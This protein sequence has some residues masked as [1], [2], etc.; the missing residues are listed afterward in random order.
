MIG[1][2]AHEEYGIKKYI[3]VIG[4]MLTAGAVGIFIFDMLIF[5]YLYSAFASQSDING[6]KSYGKWNLY[7]FVVSLVSS[8]LAFTMALGNYM[9]HRKKDKGADKV[10][11][12]INF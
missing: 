2:I 6:Q 1:I 5:Q 3:K 12:F 8:F 7:I 9:T 10:G 11:D 4:Y